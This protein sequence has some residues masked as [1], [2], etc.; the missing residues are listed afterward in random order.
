MTMSGWTTKTPEGLTAGESCL[1][2]WAGTTT[3]EVRCDSHLARAG[4]L[5]CAV[6]EMA[7]DEPPPRARISAHTRYTPP[8]T[9]TKKRTNFPGPLDS[10][11]E[12]EFAPP[13]TPPPELDEEVLW[14]GEDCGLNE[15]GTLLDKSSS[16]RRK[17]LD[18]LRWRLEAEKS[19]KIGE[20]LKFLVLEQ[21][22]EISELRAQLHDSKQGSLDASTKSATTSGHTDTEQLRKD[23][24]QAKRDNEALGR[25]AVAE[26]ERADNM[27]RSMQAVEQEKRIVEQV[28]VRV[29]ACPYR[30][31]RERLTSISK[32][33]K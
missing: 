17:I 24:R 33:S 18:T 7:A 20:E 12:P 11:T 21:Q 6:H 23:L 27:Q 5:G 13:I 30:A 22:H 28:L 15:S 29:H 10:V 3:T 8:W 25:R 1:L 26:E 14:D 2:R 16:A 4:A 32:S 19:V 31:C 9:D